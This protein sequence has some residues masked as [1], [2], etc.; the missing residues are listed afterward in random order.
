[1]FLVRTEVSPLKRTLPRTPD[2]STPTSSVAL[3][4]GQVAQSFLVYTA[5]IF[6]LPQRLR[7]GQ[8]GGAVTVSQM[9]ALPGPQPIPAFL[10]ST[11]I[12]LTYP[13]QP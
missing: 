4:Q 7:F 10:F 9:L 8:G 6:L 2:L 5:L 1:M 13:L 3:L 11:H 12:T